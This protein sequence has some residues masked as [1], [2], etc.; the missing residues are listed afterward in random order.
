M[1]KE[2]MLGPGPRK[3]DTEG[4]QNVISSSFAMTIRRAIVG[5][6]LLP[7]NF[8]HHS[9]SPQNVRE[10]DDDGLEMSRGDRRQSGPPATGDTS[11]SHL[12]APFNQ[13]CSRRQFGSRPRD[14]AS[15]ST[16]PAS[17]VSVATNSTAP[18]AGEATSQEPLYQHGRLDIRILVHSI[19]EPVRTAG[20]E[21][22]VRLKNYLKK[23]GVDGGPWRRLVIVGNLSECNIHCKK[24]FLLKYPTKQVHA[25]LAPRWH[26]ANS[27]SRFH[28]VDED[29]NAVGAEVPCDRR[30][31]DEDFNLSIGHV[32]KDDLLGL[33]D[34]HPHH[35]RPRSLAAG[36]LL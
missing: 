33:I 32:L 16:P 1:M 31:D 2:N 21:T 11:T 9:R 36:A 10:V 30:A 17:A 7:A 15:Q 24:L 27:G 26:L 12:L 23:K 19:R 28:G 14:A 13:G 3:G 20:E 29:A 6:S 8:P 34:G 4:G 18:D 25:G 22:E 35:L 5:E